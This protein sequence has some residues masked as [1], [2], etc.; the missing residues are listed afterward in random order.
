MRDE[1][2]VDTTTTATAGSGSVGGRG[3][4]RG[5]A[6]S[7]GM[8]M[9]EGGS[10][11]ADADGLDWAADE[12]ISQALQALARAPS[13]P[14]ENDSWGGAYDLCYSPPTTFEETMRAFLQE[15]PAQAFQCTDVWVPSR[16]PNSGRITLQF[17]GGVA[18]RGSLSEW[19]FY[20]RNFAF[21]EGQG[22]PGR[23][24]RSMTCEYREDVAS[25][26]A[27]L[28]LRRDGAQMVGVHAYFGVP[29]IQNEMVFVMV[30]YSCHSNY[31]HITQEVLEFIRHTVASW[32][33]VFAPPP[34]QALAAASADAGGG[35]LN[36]SGGAVAS[37]PRVM[38]ER[39][40]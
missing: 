34:T 40:S 33:V 39:L 21:Y 12:E 31:R 8:T 32:R 29:V 35:G 9:T 37:H 1:K 18:L 25:L 13:P 14:L 10:A 20:S 4:G 38:P 22:M 2:W 11:W 15:L 23:V 19:T 6:D 16:D 3:G 5:E 27:T 36:G 26:D 7:F 28:F 17:G 30:F 24:F